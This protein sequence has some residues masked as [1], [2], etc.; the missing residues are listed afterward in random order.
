MK[1]D[2]VYEIA[3]PPRIVIRTSAG[4]VLLEHAE[5]QRIE[6][7]GHY[8]YFHTEGRTFRI[9]KSI[10]DVDQSL[11]GTPFVRIQRAMIVNTMS[12]REMKS[13]LRGDCKLILFDGTE[14]I[15]SRLY[16]S[17]L[18]SMVGPSAVLVQD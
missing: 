17:N 4:A 7:K 9:R 16:K 3:E 8:T 1:K 2:V 14:L 13:W 15:C 10:G 6:A 18:E 11:K 12:I 5:I